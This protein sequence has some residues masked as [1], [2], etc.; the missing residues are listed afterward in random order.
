[1]ISTNTTK[2]ATLIFTV[3]SEPYKMALSF[4]TL[5]TLEYLLYVARLFTLR[6]NPTASKKTFLAQIITSYPLRVN[7]KTHCHHKLFS[8]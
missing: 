8:L 7:L 6:K 5:K 4:V 1:M 3:L 2:Y